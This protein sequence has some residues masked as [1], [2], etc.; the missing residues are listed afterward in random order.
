MSKKDLSSLDRYD[1]DQQ[2]I[3]GFDE[4]KEKKSHGNLVD[5]DTKAQ[6]KKVKNKKKS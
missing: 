1:A 5:H 6:D 2:K 4:E 3:K